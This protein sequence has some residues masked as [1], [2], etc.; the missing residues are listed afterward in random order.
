VNFVES[1]L[2]VTELFGTGLFYYRVKKDSNQNFEFKC[3]CSSRNLKRAQ[4]S[5][6]KSHFHVKNAEI[7]QS[8]KERHAGRT[9]ISE[10]QTIWA[11]G[12]SRICGFPAA[13]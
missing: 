13:I 7:T 8:I 5:M 11:K 4:L 12:P 3:K 2:L 9:Q 10:S 6:I 1:L